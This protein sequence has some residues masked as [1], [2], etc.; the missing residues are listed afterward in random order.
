MI[1]V[2]IACAA[3]GALSCIVFAL[4]CIRPALRMR[5]VIVRL[6][7]NPA[8]LAAIDAQKSGQSLAVAATTFEPAARRLAAAGF[9][10]EGA[11][12]SVSGFTTQVAVTAT[13]VETL[14]G[15]VVP[16]LRGMLAKEL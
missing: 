2:G 9:A 10:I 13:V 14:L 6:Q 8:L 4:L 3:I 11:L 16:R 15:L 5:S 12:A 7:A 1:E